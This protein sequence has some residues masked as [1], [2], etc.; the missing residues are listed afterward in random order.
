MGR[1]I[2]K[3][4]NSA[5]TQV[6]HDGVNVVE[7]LAGGTVTASL[8]TGLGVDEH[9]SRT[10]ASGTRF[11]LTDALGSTLAL[12]DSTG[13]V[14]TEYTYTPFGETTVSGAVNTNLFQFIG[15]ENDGTGRRITKTVNGQT[16]TFAYD[17]GTTSCPPVLAQ[18]LLPLTV[19]DTVLPC[20]CSIETRSFTP[21]D[22]AQDRLRQAQGERLK[23]CSSSST[24]FVLSLSKHAP[25]KRHT[26][27][28]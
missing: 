28:G 6:A 11:L 1:R 10:D 9:F 8:L 18:T 23:G 13:M 16:T 21:F 20:T 4:L 19:L 27:A 22:F 7:E 17:R 14:Q 2:Q 3:T 15:R 24:P 26:R 5:S 25:Y 12:T